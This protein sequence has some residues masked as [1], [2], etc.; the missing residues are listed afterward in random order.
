MSSVYWSVPG[1]TGPGLRKVFS[2]PCPWV[3]TPMSQNSECPVDTDQ[4]TPWYSVTTP[5]RS[6]PLRP[7]RV[8]PF[9][10]DSVGFRRGPITQWVEGCTYL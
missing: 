7:E 6:T 2:V 8:Q 3:V 1:R 9:P 4:T 5:P 10:L